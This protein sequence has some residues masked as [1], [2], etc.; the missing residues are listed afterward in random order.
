M[1]NPTTLALQAG[2]PYSATIT[3][4]NGKLV[5]ATENLFEVRAQVRKYA[6]ESAALI[7]DLTDNL[8]AVYDGDDIVIT[9][10]LTG[11]ETRALTKKSG[12][13]DVFVSDA[14]VTDA[15]A[16]KVLH[17]QLTVTA[18]VTAAS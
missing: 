12:Y 11:A 17:G 15:R 18:A 3:V 2:E 9:L 13:Y 14:D 6:S 7:V 10:S 8:S 16:Y 4:T 5:W 1:S